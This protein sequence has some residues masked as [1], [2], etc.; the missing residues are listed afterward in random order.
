MNVRDETLVKR[1]KKGDY[2]AFEELIKRYEKKVYNLVY[3][4]M[5]NREDANDILQEAFLN[6]FRKISDFKGDSR[7]STWLHRIAI[8][9]CL[10]RK[11]KTKDKKVVSLDV[12]IIANDQEEIKRELR[13][14]WSKN[15]LATLENKEVKETLSMAIDS[16]PEEY[17]TVFLLKGYNGLSNEDVAKMLKLSLPAVK[18]R[19][20]RARLFLRNKLSQYF[21]GYGVRT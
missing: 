21:K 3:R 4:I 7:F 18:S 10:M 6:A 9:L 16:L 5:G 13:D 14:D 1:A 12:P 15:P 11:R 17:R 20:H 2:A 8:N 19:L